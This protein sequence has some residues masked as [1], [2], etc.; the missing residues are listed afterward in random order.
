MRH[1][2][3]DGRRR[4]KRQIHYAERHAKTAGS[5]LRHQLPHSGDFEGSALDNVGNFGNVR[6]GSLCKRGADNAGTAYADIHH[7]VGFS[8]PVERACHEGIVLRSVAENHQL[9]R[10]E[11]IVVGGQLGTF[12]DDMSHLCDRVH[13]DAGFGGADVDGGADPF[14]LGK[15]LRNAL[16]QRVVAGSEA[17]MHKS[18]IAA[19]EVDSHLLCRSVEGVGYLDGILV[20]ACRRDHRR[21]C[22]G[23]SFID[24]GNAVLGFYLLAGSDE[25]SG[26]PADLV[27]DFAAH[28][29]DVAVGA[30]QQADSHCNGAYVQIFI[31]D[32]MDGFKN[33]FG[34][35]HSLTPG[36]IIFC[37]WS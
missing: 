19:E 33:V 18:R 28:P 15:R 10:S 26:I 30:V 17:L 25:I 11:A 2:I 22:D 12:S 32:H 8:D 37:A 13:I 20:G 7:A 16:N 9:C 34:I 4:S 14:C 29:V 23:N 3:P 27:V 36:L 5:L 1:G 31:L 21:R 35:K 24:D 6:V